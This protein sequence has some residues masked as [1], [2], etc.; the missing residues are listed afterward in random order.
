MNLTILK[1]NHIKN[2]RP[3]VQ[4]SADLNA[5]DATIRKVSQRN[6][7]GQSF[8]CEPLRIVAFVALK[9]CYFLFHN[10]FELSTDKLN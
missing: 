5:T 3:V 9:N 8:R 6:I 10:P 4:P 1:L 2:E 7:K